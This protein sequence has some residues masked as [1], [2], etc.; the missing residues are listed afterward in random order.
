MIMASDLV[1]T[2][3]IRKTKPYM[4][5]YEYSA[6]ISARAAQLTSRFESA[7][8]LIPITKPEEHDPMYIATQEVKKKLVRL[9]VRRHLP[10]GTT[11]DF[12]LQELE[13]PRI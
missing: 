10:D 5:I 13:F 11:E 2:T 1:A 4:S 6:L 7:K 8:P 9:V 12:T 3:P